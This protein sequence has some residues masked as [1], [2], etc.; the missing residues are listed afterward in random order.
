MGE[1]SFLADL[2]KGGFIMLFIL[3]C[4]IVLIAAIIERFLSLK[5]ISINVPSFMNRIQNAVTSGDIESA[6]A[7]TEQTNGP[8]AEVAKA[9]FEKWKMGR[10]RM[11]EVAEIVGNAQVYIL[12]KNLNL[13]ATI[14]GVA[15]LLGFFGTVWGM[16]QAFKRIQAL[17][18]NVNADVLA[19]GIWQAMETTFAGLFVGIIAII[20]YN[21]FVNRVRQLVFEMESRSEELIDLLENELNKRGE[22][23]ET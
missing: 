22:S 9:V 14:T 17:K 11:K 21:Y 16:I 8:L 6:R 10:A 13:I 3:A 19:G 12:E 7:I 2:S 5:N 23:R 20:F 4:S 1:T 18:G 15:P